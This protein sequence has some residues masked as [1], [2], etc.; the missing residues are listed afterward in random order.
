MPKKKKKPDTASDLYVGQPE[1]YLFDV[2]IPPAMRFNK[3]VADRTFE[4]GLSELQL[5]ATE[6]APGG[7]HLCLAIRELIRSGYLFGAEILLRPLLERVAVLAYLNKNPATGLQLWRDGWPHKSRPS[8]KVMIECIE[9]PPRTM[10]DD[11]YPQ[12]YSVHDL[13]RDRVDH[14]NR[15]V[16]ADPVGAYRN[17]IFDAERGRPVHLSGPNFKNPEY[18]GEIAMMANAL[19]C[20]LVQIVNVIFPNATSKESDSH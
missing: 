2:M 8:I 11:W 19:M 12:N 4:G 5:A 9:E 20:S 14:L 3:A 18:C 6:I 1:L 7:F 10:G 16:H 13:L 17:T 15:L